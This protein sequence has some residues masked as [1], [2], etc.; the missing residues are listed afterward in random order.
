MSEETKDAA[1]PA[2][3]PAEKQEA[4]AKTDAKPEKVK[5]SNCA[6]CNKALKR[7]MWYYRNGKFFCNK[8]CWKKSTEKVA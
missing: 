1:A 8:R 2:P 7:G 6:V 5:A 4:A 3:A